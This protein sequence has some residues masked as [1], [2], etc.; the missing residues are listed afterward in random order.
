MLEPLRSRLEL[1]LFL[2]LL[3][4]RIVEEPH[5]F[6]SSG[7]KCISNEHGKNESKRNHRRM[8]AANSLN[9]K[10]ALLSE[11]W[12]NGTLCG[13]S[14]RGSSQGSHLEPDPTLQWIEKSSSRYYGADVVHSTNA[15]EKFRRFAPRQSAGPGR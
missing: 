15:K 9:E 8:Y 5:P 3:E 11:K 2:E 12:R 10:L 6:I 14:I 1:I 4:R 7:G 13:C